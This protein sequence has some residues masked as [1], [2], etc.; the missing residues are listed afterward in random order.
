MYLA[1]TNLNFM[2]NC[3]TFVGRVIGI[4]ARM[5]FNFIRRWCSRT[6]LREVMQIVTVT[7]VITMKSMAAV[8]HISS[9]GEHNMHE[10]AHYV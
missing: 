7:V 5:I 9:A 2:Q 4:G 3:V 1:Q 6:L 10:L 8:T